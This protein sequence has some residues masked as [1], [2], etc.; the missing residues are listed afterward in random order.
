MAAGDSLR[1]PGFANSQ[2]VADCIDAARGEFLTP[3]TALTIGPTTADN[4]QFQT[5]GS[6]KFLWDEPGLTIRPNTTN[7]YDLGAASHVWKRIYS[8]TFFAGATSLVQSALISTAAALTVGTTGINNLLFKTNGLNRWLVDGA[9]GDILQ[10]A[11]DGGNIQFSKAGTGLINTV[12]A[13]I[14]AAGSVIGDATA[15][16]ASI[17]E[18]TTVSAGQGVKL[19]DL[20]SG[21]E[22]TIINASGTNCKLW[23]PSGT[24]TIANGSLGQSTTISTL[25]TMVVVRVTSVRWQI[26]SAN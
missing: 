25:T 9:T 7:V 8:T 12:T 5:N 17:N 13:G 6:G 14:S 22:C 10:N 1:V 23:P 21:Q 26:K 15:L 4:I 16:I 18:V 20:A 11:T 2:R 3:A 19:P 24:Q